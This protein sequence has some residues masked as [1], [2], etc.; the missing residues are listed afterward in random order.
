ML[1]R[2]SLG[3][4]VVVM[5]AWWVLS[6]FGPKGRGNISVQEQRWVDSVYQSLTPD[7]RL[8]QLFMVAAYSNK[9]QSHVREIEHLITHYGI[10]G[11]MFMQGGPVRQ[12]KLTNR[13][14]SI[15]KVPLL[16]AIDAEW[17]L[18]MRL[19]SS[20]HF[21]KQM[22]LGALPDDR[23]VYLMGRE[24]ALKLKRLGIHVNFSPV[25]DVN[26]N[27][28]NP[29]I[30]NR[31]FGESKEQVTARGIAYI[32]GL[33][34]HGIIAV[35][36]HFPGHG[37]TDADSHFSLPVLSHD[38]ARLT[39]VELYPFKRSFDAGVMGVMV[40]H[41]HVP[42]LD[43][44]ANRAATLSPYLVQDLLKGKMQYEGLV[45]TD[46]LNMKGV[47]RYHKPGEVDALALKA[48]NDVLLFSEDVPKAIAN[49]KQAIADSTISEQEIELRVRKMLHAKYWAGLNQYAPVDLENLSQDLSR[50]VSHVL[51]Q[52]LYEQAVT[53]VA[54][55]SNLLPFRTLD[56]IQFA[57]VSIGA[58]LNNA[59][60]Q[61]LE[62]YTSFRKFAVT[63]RSAPDSVYRTIQRELAGS[64]V[65][66][67]SLH[68][69]NN[70][71]NNNF[72]L[73]GNALGFIR[74]L[75]RDSTKKV[76]VVVMGN[77]YSLK[78]FEASDWLVCGYE[79]N[80]VSRKVV[81]QVLFG[82]LPA[83]GRLPVTA[84]P[85]FKAGMGISTPA[86]SRL[87]YSVPE[88]VGMNSGILRQID[89]I[90][91]E[92]I[93][94]GATPGCQV[95]VVK[96][97]TVVLEKGYGYYTFDRSQPVTEK[98]IYD[99]ASITKVAATLQAVMFLKDQGRL[100]LDEKLVTYLPELK[101]SNK[102]NLLVRDVLLHQ[103][104]LAAYLPF[105]KRTLVDGKLNPLYYDS[106]PSEAYPN[107]VV[108]GVYSNKVLEDSV[109]TWVVKSDLVGKYVPGG[110]FEYRYSDLGLHL[111]KRVAERLLNQPLPDFLEQ[112]F[113]AP[114]GASTLTF[115]PLDKFL[116]EQIAPTA[117]ASDFKPETP[118]QGT[119][120][121]G[122]AAILGGKAG[123]AGLFSNAND[124]AILMQMDLQNGSYG[125][126]KFFKT[127]VVT[128]F[129]QNGSKNSRR[130]L[131]W[132]KPDPQ[133]NGPTSDLAP[134][135]TFG[136]TGFTGT[137][138][139]V[140]PENNV[141]YIFLSNRV[142]PDAENDKLLQYNIRTR[143]HDV[144]Y[145]SLE[146]KP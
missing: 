64:D 126:Q 69:L 79:D 16:V 24:I 130:G 58:D 4:L 35:A 47:T 84:S 34:D 63:S 140:D 71:P 90:A 76:V 7:Q 67:V 133:G 111:M 14:Q 103:A 122:N 77:A 132:D 30:G 96:D 74:Q 55:K 101:G 78:N 10:G 134:M 27:P 106:L 26:S 120:H 54:N 31:S 119:V 137:G 145:Q 118:L 105:W 128:E 98:T 36:K 86:L 48:G 99:L 92:A 135:S 32:K 50:P 18:D 53:V 82:A 56:T 146:P 25:V 104:G 116:K 113:Y 46:A 33:Q 60:T 40:A 45:F 144:V 20:M 124:L 22:T 41:L 97:G 112:N 136:H 80:E 59:F 39:E 5:G 52:Q 142:Y 57:S 83:N 9:T 65:V 28:K 131:G 138:A 51:Q 117:P 1:K 121:D 49:I 61:S 125:G 3:L 15:S 21:A 81:P 75:Q 29:V 6:G 70:N 100:K 72:N 12:A 102:A 127:P 23:Y 19:D 37:D 89:N 44:I 17:G 141:I 66:V 107:L 91:L 115:N 13:Y 129:S 143:I 108:P 42:K 123:H 68:R 8:G 139:W 93:A 62:K 94:Y 87:R 85:K 2:Y 11:V 43:S 95:L 38:M 88:S 114:L 110:K 73:P 109:W